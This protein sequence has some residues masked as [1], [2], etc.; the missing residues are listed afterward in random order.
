[1]FGLMCICFYKNRDLGKNSSKERKVPQKMSFSPKTLFKRL[2]TSF[3]CFGSFKMFNKLSLSYKLLSKM[4]VSHSKLKGVS[5]SYNYYKYVRI[6]A[7][8]SR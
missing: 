4:E 6:N 5:T 1:M 7:Y 8:K 2:V 3:K